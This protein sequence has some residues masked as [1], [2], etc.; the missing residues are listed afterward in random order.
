LKPP[1][2]LA[3]LLV[4][5]TAAPTARSAAPPASTPPVSPSPSPALTADQRLRQVQQRRKELAAALERMRGQAQTLLG[6]VERLEIEVRL[7]GEELREAQVNLQRTNQQL[8]ATV[9]R[10]RGLEASLRAARPVLAARARALYKLGELSYLRLLL[11]VDRPSDFFNGYRFVNTLARRD[12]ERLA[13][14]RADLRAL[15]QARLDLEKRTAE[16][17]AL[18]AG[19]ERARR[20]LEADRVRKTKLLTELVESKETNAV[21]LQE[22]EE[23]EGKLSAL[24]EGT[25][26]DEVAVPIGAFKGELPW[27]VA[28]RV[29]STFGKHKHPRFDT[30]T[31]QNGIDIE[32]PVDTPVRSVHDGEVVF[33]DRFRGY[34]LMVILEHGRHHTLYAHLAEAAVVTGQRLPAGAVVGTVGASGLSGQ[35]LYFEVRIAGRP[36]D[37]LSWLKKR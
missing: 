34:G 21:F 15:E 19:L 11:S 4:L 12:K 28:G 20:N 37:P 36:E 3:A 31:V 6:Q 32:A 2:A 22:L 23:A 1:A 26:G 24:L 33:A 29:R 25:G 9:R 16:T 17:L 18:R 5:A 10:L 7:R 35:G 8:E 30:Y 27:P 13:R 14:F